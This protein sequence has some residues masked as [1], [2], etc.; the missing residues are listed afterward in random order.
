MHLTGIL[1]DDFYREIRP[2]L[3]FKTAN[4]GGQMFREHQGIR[5]DFK[6][7]E[8]SSSILRL[9]LKLK[10]THAASVVRAVYIQK[11]LENLT[12]VKLLQVLTSTRTWPGTTIVASGNGITL[13]RQFTSP[14]RSVRP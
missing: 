2:G 10:I 14:R 3:C 9:L 6:L 4:V 13:E 8:I 1:S 5:R 11:T 12:R 7:A